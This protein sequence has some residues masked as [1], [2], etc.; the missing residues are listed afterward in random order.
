MWIGT[1]ENLHKCSPLMSLLKTSIVD[2]F[3]NNNMD[4]L[5][6]GR[7]ELGN[8]NY[9]NIF[10][11]ETKE[12]DGVFES[13]KEYIDIHYII[14]GRE[15]IFWA[16]KYAQKTQP[17]QKTGDYSLGKVKYADEVELNGECCVFFPNEPHKAGVKLSKAEK[18][19]KAVIKVKV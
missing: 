14:Y 18:V 8:D 5:P 16:D 13:H 1:L 9:I 15:K 3:N 19:K 10:E 17:Y 11:Y 2:F 12:N 4:E 7:Y 6:N